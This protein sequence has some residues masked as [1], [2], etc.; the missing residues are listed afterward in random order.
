MPFVH[1]PFSFRSLD[2]LVA[3]PLFMKGIERIVLLGEKLEPLDC[4]WQILEVLLCVISALICM[5]LGFVW[6]LCY[7]PCVS[8]F[9]WLISFARYYVF[10]SPSICFWGPKY[11]R[12]YC[13]CAVNLHSRSWRRARLLLELFAS[14]DRYSC[15]GYHICPPILGVS[16]DTS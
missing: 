5:S 14:T 7:L 15:R 2:L 6:H 1:L 10:K 8:V 12:V 11:D 3:S 4:A 16:T 9:F 13:E